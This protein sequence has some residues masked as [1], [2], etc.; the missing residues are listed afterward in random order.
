MVRGSNTG[1]VEIF[2]TLPDRPWC[3]P[4]SEIPG[5]F[6][7]G[8]A[9]GAL[10]THPY[11]A[12]RLKEDWSYTSTPLLGLR[13]LFKGEPY[14]YLYLYGALNGAVSSSDYI[15]FNGRMT[16]DGLTRKN[17]HIIGR[18]LTLGAITSGICLEELK[19][20]EN[21]VILSCVHIDIRKGLFQNSKQNL[22]F[23]S[24][25]LVEIKVADFKRT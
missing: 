15:V 24:N 3:P 22:P 19:K 14:L 12:P 17:V 13:V 20:H 16:C 1:G 10:T 8:K 5:L 9:V 18:F 21:P 4:I 6:S 7:G 2:C 25:G 23:G 11:I